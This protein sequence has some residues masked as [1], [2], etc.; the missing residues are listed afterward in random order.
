MSWPF[1]FASW[2][3]VEFSARVI[4]HNGGRKIVEHEIPNGV[5]IDEDLGPEPDRF[6]IDAY[7][8]A[9][10]SIGNW[11]AAEQW[12]RARS[13]AL[14][15][16]LEQPGSGTLVHPVRGALPCRV[17]RWLFSDD[18]DE[19]GGYQRFT[20]EFKLDKSQGLTLSQPVKSPRGASDSASQELEAAAGGDVE[21]K[22]DIAGAETAR[23]ATERELLGFAIAL[24]QIKASGPAA[25]EL[26]AQAVAIA[27]DV[28]ALAI[29]PAV[30]VTQ[31]IVAA[32]DVER[33]IADASRALAAYEGL[34]KLLPAVYGSPA[35]DLNARLVSNLVRAAAAGGALRAAAAVQWASYEDA[36]GRRDALLALFDDLE[37]DASDELYSALATW[38]A[39]LIDLV[40]LEDAKLPRV[41]TYT[42]PATLPALV[43]AWRLYGDAGREFELVARNGIDNPNMVFGGRPLEILVDG[44][45]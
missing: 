3:G 29:S 37:R 13:D 42:P 17:L 26:S 11:S 7:I 12:Q 30:A 14:R 44:S 18:S 34:G 40:P 5:E 28:K 33:A 31:V 41:G 21:T 24:Q 4:L 16:A 23:A 32:R 43:V 6:T 15:V 27:R 9:P 39:E 36:V 22:L 2:R 10:L 8:V 38:R 19:Q 25:A 45:R 35:E 1:K 20:I